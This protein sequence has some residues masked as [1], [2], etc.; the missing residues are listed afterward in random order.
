MRF[1]LRDTLVGI[2]RGAVATIALSASALENG[3]VLQLKKEFEDAFT[4]YQRFSSEGDLPNAE[5]VATLALELAEQIYGTD[6]ANSAVLSFNLAKTLN[7]SQGFRWRGLRVAELAL[8]RYR[9]L[10]GDT[11]DDVVVPATLVI[12][13]LAK[14]LQVDVF[15]DE[16]TKRH[17]QMY[18]LVGFAERIAK[19]SND[20]TLL[21]NFYQNISKIGLRDSRRY[22]VEAEDLYEEIYGKNHVRTLIAAMNAASFKAG[23]AQ[24]D[25]YERIL[26]DGKDV[27]DFSPYQFALHQKLSINYLEIGN[28]D[29]ATAHLQAAGLLTSGGDDANY[30]PIYK[31]AA[32]YPRRA[33]VRGIEGYVVLEFT[34][35]RTGGVR[36]PKVIEANPPKIFDQAAI[37]AVRQFRYIPRVV[38]GEPVEVTGVTNRIAFSFDG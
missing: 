1:D 4:Q 9:D 26:R 19:R 13:V 11:A 14:G 27:E 7:A 6:H 36:D 34:V 12:Q 37:D 25:A 30:T 33:L 31:R 20:V 5:R 8:A 10:F 15:G 22:S 32:I 28:E 24:T 29:K 2:A 18:V 35:T 21:P 38:S 23:N 16:Q 17:R 3:D